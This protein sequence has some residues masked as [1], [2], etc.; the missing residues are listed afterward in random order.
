M[1]MFDGDT[2][3]STRCCTAAIVWRSCFGEGCSGARAVWS[4]QQETLASHI[5]RR[6]TVVKHS[7]P[8]STLVLLRKG[9]EHVKVG[10]L[11]RKDITPA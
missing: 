6:R 8:D 5:A 1:V 7:N 3:L 2:P 11:G 9:L 10:N 4:D